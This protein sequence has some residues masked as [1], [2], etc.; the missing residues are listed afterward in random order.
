[1]QVSHGAGPEGLHSIS[2]AERRPDS[3]E[4]IE[5]HSAKVGVLRTEG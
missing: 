4:R 5:F 3:K 1:L 2:V